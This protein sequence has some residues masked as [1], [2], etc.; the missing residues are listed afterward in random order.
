MRKTMYSGIAP[1]AMLSACLLGASVYADGLSPLPANVSPLQGGTVSITQ[2]QIDLL[3]DAQPEVAK[4]DE[5]TRSQTRAH[6]RDVLVERALLERGALEAGLNFDARVLQELEAARQNVLAQAFVRQISDPASVT[7]VEVDTEYERAISQLADTEFRMRR[8]SF[9]DQSEAVD[10]ADAL[11]AGRAFE[12]VMSAIGGIH[13]ADSAPD[14]WRWIPS[15]RLPVQIRDDIQRQLQNP[16]EGVLPIA[17][18]R[19]WYVVQVQDQRDAEVP[20]K[21]DMVDVLR[22]Q[23]AKNKV[24]K[25][26]SDRRAQ[27]DFQE[28]GVQTASA[29]SDGAMHQ[30][31]DHSGHVVMGTSPVDRLAY[32]T[33]HFEAG[34]LLY[35]AGKAEQALGHLSHPFAE[36]HAAE[37]NGLDGFGF[38]QSLFVAL[39]DLVAAGAYVDDV[40]QAIKSATENLYSTALNAGSRPDVTLRFILSVAKSQYPMAVSD[41]EI[42]DNKVFHDVAGYL[43]VANHWVKLLP[44]EESEALIAP[45]AH[46]LMM[47]Q[48]AAAH[49]TMPV[50]D[51]SDAIDT[52]LEGLKS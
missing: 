7:E 40:E 16:T 14:Q 13:P 12:D 8:L 26:L 19:R 2:Q 21:E 41:G 38:D 3:Y 5:T 50:D 39:F 33:G 49:G 28:V 4:L 29:M 27:E 9:V 15:K 31:M 30:G 35:R 44:K 23:I 1:A 11:N 42:Q 18:D 25:W 10:A 46:L 20:T 6:V 47:N 34:V 22:E 48:N 51:F 24:H 43:T 45:I 36:A 52:I 37:W 32:M 17:L